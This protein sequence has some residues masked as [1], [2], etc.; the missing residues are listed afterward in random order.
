MQR[1]PIE[2]LLLVQGA[3]TAADKPLINDPAEGRC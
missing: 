3:P 2:K 1:I